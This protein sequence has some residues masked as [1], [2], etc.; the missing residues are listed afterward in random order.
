MRKLFLTCVVVGAGV[1]FLPAVPASADPPTSDAV[2]DYVFELEPGEDLDHWVEFALDEA[3]ISELE[4]DERIVYEYEAAINGV[5][6]RLS[7]VEAAKLDELRGRAGV[8]MLTRSFDMSAEWLEDDVE[9]TG[10]DGRVPAWPDEIVPAGITRVDG[11]SDIDYSDIHVGVVD[12]GIDRF[13]EDLADAVVGGFDCTFEGHVD[14][15]GRDGNGHGTHTAGTIAALSNGRG[16]EGVAPGASLH[17]YKVLT[18]EGS[19]SYAGVLCGFDRAMVDGVDVVSAS[20]GGGNDQSVCDSSDSMHTGICNLV[21]SGA[22][23]VVAAGNDSMDALT[24][25]PANYPEVVTVSAIATYGVDK[26]GSNP[27]PFGCADYPQADNELAFFSNTGSVVDLT[28]PGVCVLSTLPNNSYGV[29]SGTSMATPHAAGV[30]AAGLACGKTVEEIL[31]FADEY[32]ARWEGDV[33]YD[34]EPLAIVPEGC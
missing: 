3:G 34:H 14:D 19:G 12:T 18:A 17:I 20:L 9:V 13:H 7:E 16:V 2:V 25:S 15:W 31:T 8:R 6:L 5:W 23:V 4:Q 1:A 22:A 21:A 11:G 33:D 28:A 32:N 10:S 26:P 29:A 30:I 24:K 27:P